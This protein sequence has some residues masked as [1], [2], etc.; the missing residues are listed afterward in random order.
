LLQEMFGYALSGDTSLQKIML[1]VTTYRMPIEGREE[2]LAAA[3]VRS[4]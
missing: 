1:L 3:G 4:A 2:W